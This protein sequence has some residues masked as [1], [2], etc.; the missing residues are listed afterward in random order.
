MKN[1][2]IW[3][4]LAAAVIGGIGWLWYDSATKPL[5]GVAVADLGREHVPPGTKVDYNSN[6]PT[7]GNHYSE[8]TRKGVYDQPKDDGNL[9]HSLEHGY[10][11]VSYNCEVHPQSFRFVPRVSAHKE[12]DEGTDSTGSSRAESAESTSSGILSNPDWQ[13]QECKDLVE[14]LKG[15][16]EKKGQER[17]IVVPRPSLDTRIALTAW[18]RI[19]KFND[20]DEQRITRFIDA[21]RNHGPE[22][23]VE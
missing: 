10:I 19:D 20:F 3:I 16:Y 2:L 5:P 23:T 7:S 13:L 17:L 11:I 4:L 1:N 21:H 18:A 12:E 15:V 8:W 9:I 22:K 14:R 6:P